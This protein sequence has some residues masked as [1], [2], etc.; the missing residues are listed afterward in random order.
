MP[1]LTTR[2]VFT[3]LAQ[4]GATVAGIKASYDLDDVPEKLT[5]EKVP[6]LLALAGTNAPGFRTNAMLGGAAQLEFDAVHL[7]LV[8]PSDVR[9]AQVLPECFS[10]LDSYIAALVAQPFLQAI[11]A[12]AFHDAPQVRIETGVF[13]WGD[14]R[15]HGVKFTHRV[16]LNL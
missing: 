1:T 5:R 13:D 2:G 7:L 3:A 12:P 10:L 8:K 9:Q 16:L 6:C 4:F 14:L 15:W 11:T